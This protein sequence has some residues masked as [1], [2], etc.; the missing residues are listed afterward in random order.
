MPQKLSAQILDAMPWLD[1]PAEAVQKVLTPLLGANGHK[2][3]KAML[4][5]TKLSAQILDAMPWLDGPAEAVQQALRPLLGAE[6]RKDVKDILNGTWFGHPLHPALVVLPLGCWTTT[7]VLD[8]A[9]ME[10]AADLSLQ[11]G[12][13]GALAAA[14]TGAAQWQDTWGKARRLGFL[15][16][17]LNLGAAGIY[18][19]SGM[20]RAQ[21]ARKTGVLL[22]SLGYGVGLFS[23]WLG[24]DLAYDLGI[25]VNHTAFAEP[26]SDWTEVLNE[27]DLAEN[28]PRR[29]VA[30]GVPIMV[31]RQGPEIFAIAAT[32][33]HL[34][35]PLDEGQLADETVTCPWHGSVFSV[36]DGMVLHGPATMPQPDFDVRV[37]GGRIAVRARAQ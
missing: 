1:G 19:A 30:K 7:M 15:H 20:L 17:S 11:L 29:V 32:C 31:L 21:G 10:D 9:G 33:S 6:G 37:Q 4:N 27:S 36:R 23:A 13:F 24:G 18:I 22:S 12:V 34:G 3:V 8:L 26:P 25:G 35:G 2:D 28:T 14:A 5:G 16:A